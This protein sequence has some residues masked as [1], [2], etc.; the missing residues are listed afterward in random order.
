M[1]PLLLFVELLD[2]FVFGAR[3][4]AWPALRDDLGLTYAEVGALLALPLFVSNLIEAPIYLLGDS[5]RRRR[6]ILGGGACFAGALLAITL[7]PRFWVLLLALIVW[8]S[9]CGAFVNISQAALVDEDHSRREHN[10]ARWTLAGS[11]GAV[12]GT[13]AVGAVESAELSWRLPFLVA[14]GFAFATVA[15]AL[16][17]PVGYIPRPAGPAEPILTTLRDGVVWTVGALRRRDVLR[18]LALLE[19]ADLVGDV[20]LGYLALYLVDVAGASPTEAAFGVGLWTIGGLMGDLLVVFLLEHIPGLSYVRL[21]GVATIVLLFGFLAVAPLAAKL[22]FSAALGVAIGGRYAILEAQ[23]YQAL[24]GRAASVHVLNNV[25]NLIGSLL[26]ALL[27]ALAGAWGLGPA[28][29]LMMLGPLA[30]TVGTW[31]TTR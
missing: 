10:M 28:M 6:L 2:E 15:V 1:V 23:L 25:G 16:R 3:E 4:A 21:N 8:C 13:F 11:I 12:A 14:T 26:P 22:A 31:R 5:W 17:V 24:P 7:S 29:W 18:W 27:G 30:V 20:L 9:A 19:V